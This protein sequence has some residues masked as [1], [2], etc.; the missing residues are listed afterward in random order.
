[1][2]ACTCH[3]FKND[4]DNFCAEEVAKGQQLSGDTINAT[5]RLHRAQLLVESLGG[6]VCRPGGLMG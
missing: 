2:H 6:A 4:I 3:R 5:Q 1:V